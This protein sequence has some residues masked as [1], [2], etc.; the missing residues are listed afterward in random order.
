[1][2]QIQDYS[3]LRVPDYKR[4]KDYMIEIY[5]LK[6]NAIAISLLIGMYWLHLRVLLTLSVLTVTFDE[7]LTMISLMATVYLRF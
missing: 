1:M 6:L 3:L 5:Y 2:V 7:L 4:I